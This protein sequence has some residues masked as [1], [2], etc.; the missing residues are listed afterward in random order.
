ML[1]ADIDAYTAKGDNLEHLQGRLV[2]LRP[3]VDQ[4]DQFAQLQ[5]LFCHLFLQVEAE[6]FKVTTRNEIP[7]IIAVIQEIGGLVHYDP[8]RIEPKVAKR[9]IDIL[10]VVTARD[11]VVEHGTWSNTSASWSS[12]RTSTP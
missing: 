6:R 2:S 7:R 8:A 10:A 12:M 4:A 9:L 3:R 5:K 11:M 1:M